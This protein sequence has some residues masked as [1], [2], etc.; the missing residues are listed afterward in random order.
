AELRTLVSNLSKDGIDPNSV[1]LLGD[2]LGYNVGISWARHQEDG[3]Y[4][5]V[6]VCAGVE[7]ADYFAD[8]A[9]TPGARS[10]D[11]YANNPL[12][13]GIARRI[14]PELRSYIQERLPEYMVPSAFVLMDS[15]PLTPNGKIDRRAL[16]APEQF[17]P[18]LGTDFIAPRTPVEEVLAG[19][20]SKVLGIE[21]IGIHD[22]FFEMGGH[23]LLATQVISRIRES[24]DVELPLRRL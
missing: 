19:I 8:L 2:E 5:V 20:W 1:W 13:G 15:L 3:S 18:E 10:L 22:D 12:R 23:S 16:P 24:F 7:T 21:P 6:F 17:R 14:V 11:H 9:E 4:D